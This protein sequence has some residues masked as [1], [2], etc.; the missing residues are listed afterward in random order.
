MFLP[1]PTICLQKRNFLYNQVNWDVTLYYATSGNLGQ[2]TV[3]D[4]FNSQLYVTT[5]RTYQSMGGRMTVNAS[6]GQGIAC[7][8]EYAYIVGPPL[9][10]DQEITNRLLNL[11]S[12][13]ETLNLLCGIAQVE[14]T[15]T[16][17]TTRTLFGK[18]AKWPT[19]SFGN[20]GAYIGLMQVPLTMADAWD[21]LNNTNMGACIFN[22]KKRIARNIER[23]IRNDPDHPE[24]RDLRPLTDFE[25][26]NMALVLYNGPWANNPNM[27]YYIPYV[28]CT[29]DWIINTANNPAGVFYADSVRVAA[30]SKAP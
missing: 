4:S 1:S 8:V 2:Y 21:W 12:H 10:L 11:Y 9:I 16:Q 6:S 14:S 5:T 20:G 18:D 25:N 30:D 7:P 13:G 23:D 24:Y 3:S 28:G 22:E 26:E 15:Y 29:V 19:E 17:F 27:Q